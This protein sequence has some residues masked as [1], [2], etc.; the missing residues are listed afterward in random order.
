MFG[1][2]PTNP[3]ELKEYCLRALGKPVIRIEISDQQCYDR[4]HDAI[5]QFVHRHYDGVNETWEVYKVT[6][7]DVTR[8]YI[9]LPPSWKAVTDIIDPL[10]NAGNGLTG[11]EFDNFNF[12]LANSDF[13]NQWATGGM[14]VSTWILFQEKLELIRRYFNP[15]RRFRHNGTT[16]EFV[17]SGSGWLVK[18]YC[19]V[20][21]GYKSVD[22]KKV[23]GTDGERNIWNNEWIKKY[24]TAL[25]G[26]Q[27]GNNISKFDGVQLPG[28]LVMRGQDIHERYATEVAKL[29][30]EFSAKYELPFFFELA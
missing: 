15:D 18:D 3:Y 16:G 14:M 19:F 4:I 24:A 11:D 13:F 29:E 23:G 1:S 28:G 22:T 6:E 20:L 21:H 26:R 30:D 9:Q 10:R 2:E 17:L 12:R 8:G 27:W 7:A 5:Q 25:L